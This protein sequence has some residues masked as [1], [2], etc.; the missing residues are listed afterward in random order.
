MVD[1]VE[2][3]FNSELVKTL[4][5]SLS[6]HG[7]IYAS[8]LAREEDLTLSAVQKQ[9]ARFEKAGL[10]VSREIGKT[11][12]Y[13]FNSKNPYVQPL[14]VMLKIAQENSPTAT[15]RKASPKPPTTEE[16]EDEKLWLY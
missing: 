3:I 8:R 16:V 10:L 5:V 9:L 11:R 1:M 7:E 15:R 13:S 12:V 2:T 4:M 6:N 14:T